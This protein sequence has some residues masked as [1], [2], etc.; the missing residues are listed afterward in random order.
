MKL[1]FYQ[2]LLGKKL[3]LTIAGFLAM[4]TFSFGQSTDPSHQCGSD[5]KALLAEHPEYLELYAQFEANWETAKQ[6][7]D[8]SSF[9]RSTS[10]KYIIPVVVHVLHLGGTENITA[11]QVKSQ[12]TAMNTL[13]G[14]QSPGLSGLS[15]FPAFDTLV[16]KFNGADTVY[17]SGPGSQLLNKFE[18]RLATKDPLGNCSDGIVR[19]YTEKADNATNVTKF[20]GKSYWDRS[21]Y[22]NFWSIKTFDD[23]SLLGYAQFPFA[24]GSQ[25]PLTSTDGVA[26]IHTVVGTT[27][28][29]TGQTG[30]TPTHESGHWL[31]LFHI[32][33]DDFCAS[34]GIDDTPIH[35]GPDFCNGGFPVLGN[36]PTNTVSID[37]GIHCPPSL[38]YTAECYTDTNSTDSAL[39]ALNLMRRNDIG[40]QWMNF[41]DYTNDEYQWMFTE[42][43]YRKM[44]VTMETVAF[45][46]SLN[47]AAN[48]LATGTDAA[49]QATPCHASPIADLWS[50]D[51]S[52]N[53]IV[54][55]LICAGGDITYRDGTY[56]LSNPGS[57]AHTRAW[58]VPG[59]T[60][61]TSTA[62]A[63]VIV[64]SN[65][66]DYTATLTSTNPDGTSTKTWTDY[67]HVSPT[68]ADDSKYIYYDDFEYSTSYYEQ[69]KWINLN[70]GID[71]AN[72][73]EQTTST[74]YM[75][76][77]AMVMKNDNNIIYEQDFLIS[78][79]FN[80]T[81]ISNAKLYFKYAGARKSAM[82]WAIQKDQLQVYFSTNCGEN[83]TIRPI[84]ID[85]VTRTTISGDTLYPAGLVSGNFVPTNAAQWNEGEVDISAPYNAASN[86]RVM[87]VWTSGGANGNDFYIDQFNISNS[88]SIGI[89]ENKDQ[90]DYSVY[91]NPVTGISQVYFKLIE[92]SRVTVDVID[93][94]GRTVQQLYS[95]EMQMGEQYLK[96]NNAD[97]NAAGIYM[98]RLTVNGVVSIRKV[99][100]E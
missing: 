16:P 94:T 39:N 65:P 52:N 35:Y 2:H 9:E 83:W 13:F 29:A 47:D 5:I 92:D 75:S 4:A 51:G 66:G 36:P 1:K 34:D 55:K 33:G 91:P 59:G 28:T 20:K 85:G 18:F 15:G 56:N 79:S 74:G 50:R 77:K 72:G 11:A 58:D 25:F 38:P 30:A 44:N 57:V 95:G 97:F 70:Q 26:L 46:G 76:S 87:F 14:M 60:P 3:S 10:G 45:R 69:G 93:I 19:I 24:F 17:T 61:S 21:K 6:E 22:F 37:V 90:I 7:M 80:M 42:Q 62:T 53:F 43:Q 68:Q 31:G 99:I 82:P 64:Y 73:W 100:I 96:L 67:I 41:M 81:T 40:R 89:E 49:S 12:I 71:P 86:L 98:V 32:W 54:K 84:K 27:G 78:P 63:P 48:H 23:P 8:F 88:Q